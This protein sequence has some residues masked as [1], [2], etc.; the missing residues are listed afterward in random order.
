MNAIEMLEHQHRHLERQFEE[1]EE[2]RGE[3]RQILFDQIADSLVMHAA[4][5]ERHFYPVLRAAD[6]TLRVPES[7]RG[8]LTI[9]RVL[10]RLLA[11]D[12]EA[13]V[14]EARLEVLREEVGHHV[15]DEEAELFPAARELLDGDQLEGIG[16]EML[17][18]MA[19]LLKEEPKPEAGSAGEK[20]FPRE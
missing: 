5:E 10:A 9:K 2:A 15:K 14:F 8:H 6:S 11:T 17:A 12:A 3:D 1:L 16:Q 4:I 19:E 20:V 18:T 7:Q 13:E